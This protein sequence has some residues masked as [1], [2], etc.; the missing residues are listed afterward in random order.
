MVKKVTKYGLAAAVTV[1]VPA[2]LFSDPALAISWGKRQPD[3]MVCRELLGK[4]HDHD[5]HG[6]GKTQS[7]ALASAIRR[8]HWFTSFEYGKRWSD[9]GIARRKT[10][11][12]S[13]GRRGWKCEVEG[14]PCRH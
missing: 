13:I 7:E 3:G 10:A 4:P 8:W 9:W 14:Q 2:F 1:M 5:G 11:K 12:C 6:H